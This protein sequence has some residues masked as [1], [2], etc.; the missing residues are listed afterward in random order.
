MHLLLPCG[1]SLV[2]DQLLRSRI[3]AEFGENADNIYLYPSGMSAISKSL[4][5]C[6]LLNPGVRSVQFGFPY[7]DALKV[8][9]VFGPGALF[10]PNGDDKDIDDLAARLT[11][12]KF[13]CVL[14]EFPGN[15]LLTLAN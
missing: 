15:P 13:S 1:S 6:Q 3:A 10:Y 5:M 8:Q 4:Q 9:T 7:L 12:E 11:H 2:V 14:L